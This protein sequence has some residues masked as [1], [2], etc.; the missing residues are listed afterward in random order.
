MKRGGGGGGGGEKKIEKV[1]HPLHLKSY[2]YGTCD[3]GGLREFSSEVRCIRGVIFFQGLSN[4]D[5][6]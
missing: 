2:I 1:M 4:Y 3:G 6:D 5:K